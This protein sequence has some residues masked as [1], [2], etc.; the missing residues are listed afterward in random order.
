MVPM[1]WP[2]AP[3]AR[4]APE[5]ISMPEALPVSAMAVAESSTRELMVTGVLVMA[6][7][8]VKR[9]LS[10]SVPVMAVLSEMYSVEASGRR[11]LAT[12]VLVTKV[13]PKPVS[14]RWPTSQGM[15][16]ILVEAAA[17]PPPTSAL[18]KA[19]FPVASL[20][21]IWL[22]VP[23][24]APRALPRT[25]AVARPVR[26]MPALVLMTRSATALV[27]LPKAVMVLWPAPSVREP[28]VSALVFP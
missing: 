7:V 18:S 12:T 1:L 9:M 4:R 21:R 2:A 16:L 3:A 10:V 5:V 20:T 24:L 27:A 22:R 11:P 23:E 19:V 25:K 28:I 14:V 13:F 17:P 15:M 26:E 8:A 6:A